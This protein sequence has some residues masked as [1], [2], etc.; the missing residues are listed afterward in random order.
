MIFRHWKM[1]NSWFSRQVVVPAFLRVPP[2]THCV[3]H[4]NQLP[5]SVDSLAMLFCICFVLSNAVVKE[6]A[7]APA[8]EGIAVRIADTSQLAAAT[9]DTFCILPQ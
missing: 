4:I 3:G 2:V 5:V 8:A 7:C 6:T 1:F 9:M